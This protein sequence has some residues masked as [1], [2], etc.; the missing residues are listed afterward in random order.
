MPDNPNARLETFCDGVFAIAITL[1]I[2]EVKVP[3][4][5]SIH[6][7]AELWTSFARLWPS[8][9]ALLLSFTVI[10]ITWVGHHN[11]LKSLNK[12][13]TH[14]QFANGFLLLT[15]IIIPFPTSLMAV[16][17]NTEYAQPAI[18]IYC[19]SGVLHNWGWRLVYYT[20][21]KPTPLVK[22]ALLDKIKKSARTGR[23]TLIIYPSLTLLAFWFPY[24][25]L[26]INVC[27]WVR[28]LY[29]VTSIKS[30]NN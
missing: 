24:T 19:L 30:D 18:V 17:L 12:T 7:K 1:L 11:L 8:F 21:F 13:S 29:V 2:L 9:F 20:T 14:F 22:D 10:L 3:P 23:Y 4:L 6:S 5:E 16:Y 25:A 26:I 28:W 27:I 15:V